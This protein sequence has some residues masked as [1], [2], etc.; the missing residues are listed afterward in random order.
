VII[1]VVAQRGDQAITVRLRLAGCPVYR[2]R[3]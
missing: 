2:H 1:D 3:H